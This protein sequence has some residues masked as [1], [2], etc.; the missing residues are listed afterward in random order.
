MERLE[1]LIS[2]SLGSLKERLELLISE[3]RHLRDLLANKE[4]EVQCLSL[5]VSEA[6]EKMSEHSMAEAKLLKTTANL[7]S[8]V[9]D[10][11]IEALFV[12]DLK[13]SFNRWKKWLAQDFKADIEAPVMRN[14]IWSIEENNRDRLYGNK[15][16]NWHG[17]M[18]EISSLREELDT[19]S[20]S[21]LR[22]EVDEESNNHKK[23]DSS[24][25]KVLNNLKSSPSLSLMSSSTSTST[26]SSL[27]EVDVNRLTHMSTDELKSYLTKLKRS[28]ASEVLGLTEQIFSL[29]REFFREGGSSLPSKKSKEFD[30]LR[31]RISEVITKLDEVL[32]EKEEVATCGNNEES[33]SGLKER[34]ELLISENHHLRDL[35]ANKDREVEVANTE[36]LKAELEREL[37]RSPFMSPSWK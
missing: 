2:E 28:H 5:Q 26:S 30:M 14:C 25:H 36:R 23:G 10:A 11:G 24:H 13:L 31:G 1:L 19:I 12:E 4:R 3:N 32:V 33:L 22:E 27:W 20:K 6:A 7:K 9:E 15:N 18:E 34:L 16:L 37:L 29:R 8:A 35:L 17:R 21:L